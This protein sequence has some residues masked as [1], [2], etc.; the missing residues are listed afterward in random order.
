MRTYNSNAAQ[1]AFMRGLMDDNQPPESWACAVLRPDGMMEIISIE[2][3]SDFTFANFKEWMGLD[4]SD[5][6]EM[7]EAIN[8]TMIAD[9]SI[10]VFVDEE[11]LLKSLPHNEVASAFAGQP[12]VGPALF[13]NADLFRAM[14]A[15]NDP[16]SE[17][18]AA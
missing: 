14:D 10:A 12:L 18:E 2:S 16:D 7:V 17:S 3:P 8:L 15:A 11:G 1:R 6:L 13:I 9:V 5:L 4:S